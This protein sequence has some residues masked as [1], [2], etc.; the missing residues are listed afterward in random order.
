MGGFS[1]LW[2]VTYPLVT[3][4][5]GSNSYPAGR[6]LGDG[7]GLNHVEP[8]LQ[9]S[10]ILAGINVFGTIGTAGYFDRYYPVNISNSHAVT[11]AAPDDTY[12]RPVP[13]T[14]DMVAT[15]SD[16]P[17]DYVKRLTPAPTIVDSSIIKSP[18]DSNNEAAA[19]TT[20][21][22]GQMLVDG[23]VADDGGVETDET[24]AARNATANDMTLLPATPVV[25]DAY[26][27]GC[28]YKADRIWI[29][30]GTAGAGTWTLTM[31]YWNGSAWAACVDQ[32]ESSSQFMDAGLC[33]WQHT[34]QSDWALKTI[35]GMNLYWLR[36][37]VTN[38]VSITTQP[39]GTQAWWELLG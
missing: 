5:A 37:E 33:Y 23:G 38:Y 2:G 28:D 19:I 29:N 34:P 39:L 8:N 3:I 7:I 35:Q 17:S 6:H 16:T 26:M 36:I 12:N 9:P 25:G 27:F 11:I 13:V 14:T 21:V 18:D 4:S 31:K 1:T 15:Y 24:T 22:S 30:I 32:E 20:E 10:Y